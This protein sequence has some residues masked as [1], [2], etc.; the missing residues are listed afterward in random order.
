MWVDRREWQLL[1]GMS[2]GNRLA[3]P[4]LGVCNITKKKEGKED[5]GPLGNKG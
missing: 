1:Y 4:T 3:N 5:N 2:K